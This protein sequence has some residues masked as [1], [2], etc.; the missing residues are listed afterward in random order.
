[1]SLGDVQQHPELTKMPKG[2]VDFTIEEGDLA[3]LITTIST[4]TGKRFIYG[5]KVRK[6]RS[7]S[8]R[9]RTSDHAGRGVPGVPLG[10]RDQRPDRHSARQIPQDRRIGGRRD[11]DHAA[12]RH[13][14]AG[15]RPRTA[16]SRASIGSRTVGAK[17]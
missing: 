12:L 9:R 5:G 15:A 14:P 16:T 7:T 4:I 1:M 2:F 17:R 13:R 8:T 10:P 3:E 11:A 6:S